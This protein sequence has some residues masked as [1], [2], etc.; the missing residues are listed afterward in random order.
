MNGEFI[1]GSSLLYVHAA[2]AGAITA[3]PA[4]VVT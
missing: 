1:K 4:Q 3:A 2:V